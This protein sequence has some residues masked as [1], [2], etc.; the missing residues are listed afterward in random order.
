MTND[1]AT[2]HHDTLSPDTAFVV[3]VAAGTDAAAGLVCG[4]IEHVVSGTSSRFTSTTEL[5]EF[6]GRVLARSPQAKRNCD[7]G[8]SK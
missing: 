1:F 6:I 7:Q 8:G 5:L 2:R 3:H 4:R